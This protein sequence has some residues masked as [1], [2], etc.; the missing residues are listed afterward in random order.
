MTVPIRRAPAS[1]GIK[2]PQW[3]AM[4]AGGNGCCKS[5]PAHQSHGGTGALFVLLSPRPVERRRAGFTATPIKHTNTSEQDAERGQ[6]ASRTPNAEKSIKC[7]PVMNG[8][9]AEP[10]HHNRDAPLPLNR[11]DV[12]VVPRKNSA[13]RRRVCRLTA[14]S[15]GPEDHTGRLVQLTCG[16]QRVQQEASVN[17][18]R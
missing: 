15:Y 6:L 13:Q 2:C 8:P 18:K 11:S 9:K 3:L 10:M 17:G 7:A 16:C 5:P 1:C 14:A 4:R 12:F